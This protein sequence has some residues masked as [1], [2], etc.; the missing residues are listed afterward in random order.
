MQLIFRLSIS[1]RPDL[2]I[3]I[4]PKNQGQAI[5]SKSSKAI[6]LD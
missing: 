1:V 5:V 3:T 4:G 6:I 2:Q